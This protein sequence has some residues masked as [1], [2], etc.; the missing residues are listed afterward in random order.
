MLEGEGPVQSGIETVDNNEY[1]PK[2]TRNR[3]ERLNTWIEI[4]L[5]WLALILVIACWR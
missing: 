5:L 4:A 2:S 1:I 3:R